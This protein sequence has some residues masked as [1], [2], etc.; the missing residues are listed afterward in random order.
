MGEEY[1]LKAQGL[2]VSYYRQGQEIVALDNVG[3]AIGAGEIIGLFGP[4]GAGKT[5]LLKCLSGLVMPRKGIIL[6]KQKEARETQRRLGVL[7]EGSRAFY[8]NL[9]GSENARYFAALKGLP[10]NSRTQAHLDL[11][12]ELLDLG[13]V[14]HQLAGTYSTGMKK[15]LSLLIALLGE[16]RLLLLDEPT[17][18]LDHASAETLKKYLRR[19]ANLGTSI[20]CATHDLP[21]IFDLTSR[22]LYLENGHL[23]PW[24]WEAMTSTPVR[25]TFL[26]A[27]EEVSTQ[28]LPE[29]VVSLEYGR[30]QISGSAN[31]PAF[32]RLLQTLLDQ[33][34]LRVIYVY[35]TA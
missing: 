20:L 6:W 23:R 25:L 28:A 14:R 4:N 26:L 18:G 35:E 10:A 12:F 11:L 30:R 19:I 3:F 13:A 1:L 24:E 31:D 9:T 27:G 7:L 17:Q 16:P 5:T 34:Q 2:T 32:Y 15:R 33:H 8:W 21:F 29:Q 22:I